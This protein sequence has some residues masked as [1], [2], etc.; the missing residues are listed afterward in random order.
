MD[1]RIIVA[2][3]ANISPQTQH[4]LRVAS[5]L[6]E[7][8]APQLAVAL[9]HVIPLPDIP[10][11]RFGIAR[12]A[13]TAE[14]RAVAEQALNRARTELHN[15]GLGSDRIA[16]LLRC[17]AP[18]DEIVKAAEELAAEFILMGSRGSSM[19]QQ[20]RRLVTGSTT[21]RVLKLAACPVM[22]AALPR[23]PNPG[24]LVA[25]YQEAIAR[26][27]HEH[28]GRLVIFTPSEAAHLFAPPQR[29]AGRKEVD[30]ASA[31]LKELAERGVLVCQRVNGELRCIND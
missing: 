5:S 10:P 16:L 12:L 23:S 31:A 25:W 18:A 3:D 9:L 30:A 24:N 26:Y 4:A 2:V 13:P 15:Q 11:S 1:R 29:A 28:P 22:I 7:R 21:H 19:K 6:L 27:L 14:Q 8:A 17:G 20:L